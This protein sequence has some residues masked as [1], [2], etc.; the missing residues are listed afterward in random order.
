ME[1]ANFKERY[2]VTPNDILAQEMGVTV[3]TV[4]HRARKLGLQK[5]RQYLHDLRHGIGGMAIPAMRERGSIPT[6]EDHYKWK[7]GKPW[8]RFK[9]P[10]Y[11]AWRNAVLERDN[12]VCQECHRKCNKH[13]KGLAAHHIKEYAQFPQLRYEVSNGLT[14]CRTCHMK[15]HGKEFEVEM[16][17]C[18]CGCG[19]MIPNRDKYSGRPRKYVNFHA[20]KVIYKE[21]P[22]PSR[23]REAGDTLI[24]CACGCGTMI[25][26][27]G[28]GGKPRR[29][30]YEHINLGR[31]RS[32]IERNKLRD[33]RKRDTHKRKRNEKGQFT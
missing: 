30:L 33:A 11:I 22:R 21:N 26:P 1:E 24:P 31:E 6:G 13:E 27:F 20:P 17:P 12:Y 32:Q 15:L 3:A 25:T 5:D 23:V 10:Q 7:G 9:D 28:A 4:I 19:T 29:Y 14:L 8:E 18:A 2:P 16:I